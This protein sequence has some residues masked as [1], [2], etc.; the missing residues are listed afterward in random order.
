M[1]FLPRS[2]MLYRWVVYTSPFYRNLVICSCVSSLWAI[3]WFFVYQ[4]C[5]TSI[6]FYQYQNELLCKESLL[7][8]EQINK[9]AIL[10]KAIGQLR[11]AVDAYDVTVCPADDTYGWV[12]AL[13]DNV[14]SSGLAVISCEVGCTQKKI[15]CCRPR[16]RMH[17]QGTLLQLHDFFKKTNQKMPLLSCNSLSVLCV[18]DT[19]Y[20]ISCMFNIVALAQ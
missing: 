5:A 7:C 20:S 14:E 15:W 12:S 6:D 1:F 18:K 4:P 10:E 9:I 19:T 13:V 11:T 3:W 17:M 16:V 8:T 2:T